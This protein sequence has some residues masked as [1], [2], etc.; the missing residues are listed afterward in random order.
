MSGTT[1]SPPP[2]PDGVLHAV[3]A[4]VGIAFSSSWG[5]MALLAAFAVPKY[6]HLYTELDL[7]RLV[8]MVGWGPLLLGVLGMIAWPII[9]WAVRRRVDAVLA[10]AS[11][12]NALLLAVILAVVVIGLFLPLV[13]VIEQLGEGGA[14]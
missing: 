6:E 1:S 9:T 10:I 8:L 4:A 7:T 14:A 2:P 12:V 13:V 11:I 3:L 5:A